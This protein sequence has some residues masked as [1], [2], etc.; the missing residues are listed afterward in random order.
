MSAHAPD[1]KARTRI[2]GQAIRAA[3]ARRTRMI[4]HRVILGALA[5][6]VATWFLIAVALASGH[7]PALSKSTATTA[8]TTVIPTTTTTAQTSTT[9]QS[10]TSD[11]SSG[12]SAV[13]TRQS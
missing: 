12:T 8:T 11:Q 9:A 5:L 3:R 2:D 10:T 1:P 7:D 6:F 13:T 4:R